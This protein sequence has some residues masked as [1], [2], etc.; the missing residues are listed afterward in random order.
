MRDRGCL[1]T[2]SAEEVMGCR[3]GMIGKKRERHSVKAGVCSLPEARRNQR[4]FSRKGNGGEE[5]R[6]KKA[7]SKTGKGKRYR[8]KN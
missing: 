7:L 4:G 8:I 2:R 6:N 1:C 5:C 3:R